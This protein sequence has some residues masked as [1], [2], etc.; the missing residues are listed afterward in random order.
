MRDLLGFNSVVIYEKYNLSQY[1]VDFL[2]FENNFI[3]T[4]IAR[5]LIFRGKRSG[6][7]RSFTMDVDPAYKKIQKVRGNFQWYILESK[8]FISSIS[9]SIEKENGKLVSFNG[10]GITFCLSIKETFFS[11]INATDFKKATNISN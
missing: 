3:Q 6:I 8:S 2:S 11:Q 7:I 10:Q 1:P 4:D 9:F 5:C